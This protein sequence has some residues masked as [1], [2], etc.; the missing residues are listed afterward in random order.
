MQGCKNRIL[1]IINN[2]LIQILFK[3]H[4]FNQTLPES[5][6]ALIIQE[7]KDLSMIRQHINCAYILKPS[8]QYIHNNSA[9]TQHR[10]INKCINFLS[11]K[12]QLL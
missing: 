6:N 5:Y 4:Y 12:K 2:K 9:N 8:T 3:S 11:L 7:C 1:V 10:H